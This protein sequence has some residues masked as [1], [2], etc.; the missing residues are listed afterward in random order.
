MSDPTFPALHGRP[1]SGWL[2]DPNGLCRF[3]DRWHVFFQH[4][5]DAPTHG[6]IT[7]GHVSSTD[8]LHWREEPVALRPRPG[9]VDAAGCWSGCVVD[10]DGTPTALY[11]AVREHASDAW[12]TLA[13]G[14]AELRTWVQGPP[15]VARPDDPEVAEVRDPFAF[16][17]GGRRYV[18]QGAGRPEPGARPRL[19]VHDASDLEHWLPA[20]TLL[21]DTDPVAATVAAADIW[22]C[23]N[24]FPLD[25]RWVLLLSLWRAERPGEG[26]LAGVRY[27]LGDLRPDPD[28]GAPRFVAESGGT[29]DSGPAFYAPQVLVQPDRVL[30]WG[31]SWELD[32][33]ADQVAAA[34]WAGSLTF[35]RELVITEGAL[36]DRPARELTALRREP[37][38]AGAPIDVPAFELEADGLLGLSLR[39]GDRDQPVLEPGGA[40]PGPLRVLVDGSMIEIFGPTGSRTTRAYP[41]EDSVWV[42]SGPATGWVLGLP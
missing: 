15:V 38:D 37:L 24:L 34:G 5:P 41:A 16:A 28:T 13:R 9:E 7:W 27:L 42:V 33:S 3:G 40:G 2:N 25:G 36:V 21:D 20:G 4:N 23:P 17:F 29:L 22:E 11:T 30:L 10:D 31:W 35:P 6:A 14:D 18:V 32:R 8:L 12:A 1:A 19:L 26:T 39:T